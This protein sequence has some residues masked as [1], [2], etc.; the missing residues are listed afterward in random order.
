MHERVL[1]VCSED[2]SW[3]VFLLTGTD[4]TSL[5]WISCLTFP[6]NL[7]PG[8]NMASGGNSGQVGDVEEDA[9]QLIFP[10]GNVKSV[11]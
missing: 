3:G 10:K 9:S 5:W 1:E 4:C 11:M 8:N 2:I 6:F 7:S